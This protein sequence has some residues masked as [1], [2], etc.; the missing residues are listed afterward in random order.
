MST[1]AR[2][3][4]SR[5]NR[6]AQL[7]TIA[8]GIIRA[9]GSDALTLG[10][11]AERAGVTKPVVYDHFG[12]RAGLLAALFR[13]FDARQDALMDAALDASPLTL[14]GRAQAMAA[15]YVDCVL[16]QGREIPGVVAALEGSPEL[17]Q[18]MR[19]FRTMFLKKCRALFLPFA[20]SGE[21]RDPAL[22]SMMGAA[23][24]LSYAAAIGEVTRED[25][26]AELA[27]AIHAMA[28]VR[29]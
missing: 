29:A 10:H 2:T 12:T 14:E 16:A 22:W 27:R 18:I 21:I 17:E 15:A 13:D 1:P 4:M 9:E 26:I 8:W 19:A 5:E 3:R 23:Q 20:P 25:A 24:L 11:L 7:M 28:G 6:L